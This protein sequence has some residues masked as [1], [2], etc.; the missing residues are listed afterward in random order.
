VGKVELPS[1]HEDQDMI[2]PLAQMFLEN[3]AKEKRK[4][5]KS[6]SN[7]AIIIL[8]EYP[9][10]GNIRELKNTIER[11]VLLHNDTILEPD[12]ITFLPGT[13]PSEVES[14]K[15]TAQDFSD[16][17]LPRETFFLRDFEKLIVDKAIKKFKGNKSKTASYLGISRN[18][19]QKRLEE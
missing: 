18:T 19:L 3:F 2:A 5:F 1:L 11:V 9:W 8:Q 4:N 12:H 14:D 6:I 13:K 7:D 16:I 17:L 10:I 15:A